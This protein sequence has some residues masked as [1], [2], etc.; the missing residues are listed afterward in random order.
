MSQTHAWSG[1]WRQRLLSTVE[2]DPRQLRQ[3][4]VASIFL[5]STST[6]LGIH[7]LLQADRA[8]CDLL[9]GRFMSQANGVAGSRR[10]DALEYVAVPPQGAQWAGDLRRACVPAGRRAPST[11]DVLI[12]AVAASLGA[13][14]VTRSAKDFEAFDVPALGYGEPPG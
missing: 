2:S 14:V 3:A 12:A 4:P 13:T 10:L 5:G 1:T 7:Q 11:T 6:Q 8:P 9:T